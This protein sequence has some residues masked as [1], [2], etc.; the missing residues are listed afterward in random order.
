MKD[1]DYFIPKMGWMI[2]I[3]S[4]LSIG[5][6]WAQIPEKIHFQGMLTDEK[7][8][9]IQSGQH[10]LVFS[11]WNEQKPSDSNAALWKET[12]IVTVEN[13][14]YSVLLGS[15][16]PFSNPDKNPSTQDALTFAS[17]YFLDIQYKKRS[18]TTNGKRFPLTTV[19]TAFRASTVEGRL[20]T[21]I[22][23]N[24]RIQPKD[25]I[26]FAIGGVHVT[27][28][29]AS[30]NK[31][32][33]V[34]IK[35]ADTTPKGVY[36]NCQD[37]IVSPQTVGSTKSSITL[38]QAL[39]ELTVISDGQ[40]W[41]GM[42]QQHISLNHLNLV[43]TI[44]AA[45]IKDGTIT[46]K[47]I[48]PDAG[49]SYKQ[50]T[51][52]NSIQGRDIVTA[53][54]KGSHLQKQSIS[55]IHM[56]LDAAIAYTKLDLDGQIQSS[57]LKINSVDSKIIQDLSIADA[58]IAKNAAISYNK[59]SLFGQIRS[60]DL[61]SECVDSQ[62]IKNQTI[63]DEDIS[64]K[65]AISYTKLALSGQIQ[66]TDLTHECVNSHIIK[67]QSIINEDISPDAKI[68]YNK[69]DLARAIQHSDLQTDS[70][71]SEIIQD[72]TIRNIDIANNARIQYKKLKLTDSIRTL[73]IRDQTITPSK[74]NHL[75]SMG[76]ENQALASD[77]QGGFK[78]THMNVLDNVYVVGAGSVYETIDDALAVAKTHTRPI[79]IKLGPGVF[80]GQ[81]V[82]RSNMCIEGAG[83]HLT[84]IRF[85]GGDQGTSSSAT[86]V[87]Y[88]DVEL[89]NLTIIS[90]ATGSKYPNAI[91]LYNLASTTIKNITIRV[92]GG[93]AYNY[94][95]YNDR[96]L[97][98]I[99]HVRVNVRSTIT[100]E[101]WN[102]GIYSEFSDA[103]IKN[104]VIESWG[105]DRTFGIANKS[106]FPIITHTRITASAGVMKNRGIWNESSSPRIS[107]TEV[108]VS[109]VCHDNFGIENYNNS[110]PI[111]KQAMVKAVGLTSYGLYQWGSS[112]DAIRI[113][114]S[115]ISG[116]TNAIY[117]SN[118]QF[119]VSH[120]QIEGEISG[121][122][123]CVGAF[124]RDFFPLDAGC[125]RY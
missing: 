63:T 6:G 68:Q 125:R 111:I 47:D 86:V 3:F 18:L 5:I 50:L 110:S 11:I 22:T 34:T 39:E 96:C 114:S 48:S 58:D 30:T 43:N 16:T 23:K 116:E 98:T 109:G 71:D 33:L 62:I 60:T 1:H 92:L 101:S 75:K 59:L 13:G 80:H 112:Q 57:D 97:P 20:V 90:D 45:D 61:R 81:V 77:G 14:V 28:P 121:K 32:R 37:Q 88:T 53:T 85:H 15:N 87:G 10:S 106:S 52:F 66:Y 107:N 7:G 73:D 42:G 55:N 104:V 89:R 94:G 51:L 31:D 56:A 19:W 49:I 64:L 4:I 105:G 69:L 118:A 21:S 41:W 84:S 95:I 72:K 74:L 102:Y 54:I 93:K 65:A 46:R 120:S 108:I 26:V 115:T 122:I 91:G 123:R 44:K 76:E 82:T 40:K 83:Q 113:Y 36:I 103:H 9:L 17:P 35:K 117:G 119:L 124:D 70:V 67:N 78:W 8:Q 25:D 100:E 27:L 99:T 12:H 79:L 2:W 38:T 29:K 24:H